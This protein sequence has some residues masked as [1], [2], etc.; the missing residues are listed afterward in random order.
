MHIYLFGFR[1]GHSISTDANKRMIASY[2]K[3]SNRFLVAAASNQFEIN[4]FTSNLNI[5]GPSLRAPIKYSP[6]Y[7]IDEHCGRVKLFYA[8]R[9]QSRSAS[10]MG[11]NGENT[12]CCGS[13]LKPMCARFLLQRLFYHQQF[14][15]SSNL[16]RIETIRGALKTI[17]ARCICN[18]YGVE[19]CFCGSGRT[20]QV[21]TNHNSNNVAC[22][23]GNKPSTT[24]G[25]KSRHT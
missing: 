11:W 22:T 16:V 9:C 8:S 17:T 25:R 13:Q 2:G 1:P 3:C 19:P 12:H 6:K 4:L 18:K 15:T 14:V 20:K 24:T 5:Y 7:P 21:Y 23:V 10:N